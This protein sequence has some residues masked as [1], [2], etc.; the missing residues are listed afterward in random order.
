MLLPPEPSTTARTGLMPWSART[1]LLSG[2]SVAGIG[3]YFVFIRPP[4]LPEDPRYIGTSL[5]QIQSVLPGLSTWLRHVFWVMG[6]YIFAT[7]LL[8]CYI[9]ASGFRTR[10]PGAAIVVAL[11][12]CASIGL[13]TIVNFLI[14]SD[15]KW[16]L[17]LLAATW[18]A[19]LALYCLEGR[20]R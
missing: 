16:L 6:G 12:G 14:R 18:A 8:T 3:V 4:L 5:L 15:F 7:G 1:L 20:Q 10:S 19:A 9:A 2:V 13:M 17:L 11:A